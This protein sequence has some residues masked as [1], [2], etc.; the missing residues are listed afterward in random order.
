VP[1]ENV[2]PPHG[3]PAGAAQTGKPGRGKA[4]RK[5]SAPRKQG[6]RRKT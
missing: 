1:A 2:K 6:A 3:N 4:G 5:Q